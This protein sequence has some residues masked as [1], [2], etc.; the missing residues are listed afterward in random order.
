[1]KKLFEISLILFTPI[2]LFAHSLVLSLYDNNDGTISVVG[3][4]NTGESAAGALVKLEA[5]HSGEILFQQRLTDDE[6]VITI[7]KI[8]YKVI[9]DGGE[10]HT[11][12]KM[13]IAPQNGFEKVEEKKE[14]KTETKKEEKPS[15]NL[16]QISS[17]PAV[18]ISI[19]LAFVLLFATIFISIKNTNKL[20][21]EIQK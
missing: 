18:T 21:K 3:E 11:Q 7:P 4:F 17:S 12:E 8:P 14:L 13:G 2:Y 1:M 19:V 15:R 9:L 16:M 20:L 10:G 6:M 5:I